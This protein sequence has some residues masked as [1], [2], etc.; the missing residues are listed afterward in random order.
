MTKTNQNLGTS[1]EPFI[2][3]DDAI[4]DVVVYDEEGNVFDLTGATITYTIREYADSAA[5]ITKTT[6]SGITITDGQNGEFEINLDSSDTEDLY[7]KYV[8]RC[9]V[10]KGGDMVH[11]FIGTV[12]VDK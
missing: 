10:E 1:E 5:E 12:E 4:L 3:G 6:G 11:V 2:A 8:H 9:T 7:G